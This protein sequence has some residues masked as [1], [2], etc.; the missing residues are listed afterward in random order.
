MNGKNVSIQLHKLSESLLECTNHNT[1]SHLPYLRGES[2]K[3]NCHFPEYVGKGSVGVLVLVMHEEYI[4]V[5]GRQHSSIACKAAQT[6]YL[7]VCVCRVNDTYRYHITYIASDAED[8]TK[9]NLVVV[10]IE[11]IR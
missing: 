10:S 1:I 7:F 4:V 11:T 3:K 9:H 2:E 8:F 6:Q 5:T